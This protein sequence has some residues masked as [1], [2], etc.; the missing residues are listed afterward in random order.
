[1]FGGCLDSLLSKGPIKLTWS[2]V[3]IGIQS[4]FIVFPVNLLIVGIFRH[5]RPRKKKTKKQKAHKQPA[6]P[7]ME[8]EIPDETFSP[9]VENNLTVDFLINVS[10]PCLINYAHYFC[11]QKVQHVSAIVNINR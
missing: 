9:H 4:S 11:I 8:K 2:Q 10:P 3:K 1:M 6:P 7:Q 5:S